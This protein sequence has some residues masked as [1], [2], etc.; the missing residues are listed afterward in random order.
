MIFFETHR[1][2]GHIVFLDEIIEKLCV[3]RAYVFQKSHTL[4]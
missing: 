1:H 4:T 3:L 2:I